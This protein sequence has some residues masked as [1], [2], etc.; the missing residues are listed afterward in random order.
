[1]GVAIGVVFIIIEQIA[2]TIGRIK[3][4][5]EG[6]R[7]DRE[8][9]RLIKQRTIHGVEEDTTKRREFAEPVDPN[10]PFELQLRVDHWPESKHKRRK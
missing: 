10:M 8:Q 7:D 6:A 2:V 9:K 3:L 5:L 4:R 1:M